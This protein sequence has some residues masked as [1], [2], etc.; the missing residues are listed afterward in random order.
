MRSLLAVIAIAA[1][2]GACSTD[3]T[4]SGPAPTASSEVTKPDGWRWESYRGV[5]VAVPGDWGTTSTHQRLS[6]WCVEPRTDRAPA[7]G[8]PGA[9][10]M[11]ACGVEE[12]P[13]AET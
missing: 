7:I 13:P 8:R 4:L 11:V 5:E 12:S 10:T 9:S 3:D 6:Q 1:L 2:L